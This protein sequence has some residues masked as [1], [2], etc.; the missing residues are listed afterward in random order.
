MHHVAYGLFNTQ[1]ISGTLR[2]TSGYQVDVRAVGGT[3]ID[4]KTTL[5]PGE[6]FNLSFMTPSEPGH[7]TVTLLINGRKAADW[8]I[9]TDAIYLDPVGS[10]IAPPKTYRWF[11][12][13]FN[14]IPDG[15]Y[16]RFTIPEGVT[17]MIDGADQSVDLDARDLSDARFAYEE[18]TNKTQLRIQLQPQLLAKELIFGESIAYVRY[19]PSEDATSDMLVIRP[20]TYV[21]PN[22]AKAVS[23]SSQ[24]STD[25]LWIQRQTVVHALDKRDSDAVNQQVPQIAAAEVE[26]VS[27]QKLDMLAPTAVRET[28]IDA[29]LSSL[30][31]VRSYPVQLED[32]SPTVDG[33]RLAFKDGDGQLMSHAVS[34]PVGARQAILVDEKPSEFDVHEPEFVVHD[35]HTT[36]TELEATSV[37][38]NVSDSEAPTAYHSDV[39]SL[40]SPMS[41]ALA[42]DAAQYKTVLVPPSIVSIQERPA[43]KDQ[44]SG[45]ATSYSAYGHDAAWDVA[46]SSEVFGRESK[47]IQFL[48]LSMYADVEI[49]GNFWDLTDQYRIDSFSD[50]YKVNVPNTI[51]SRNLP[52]EPAA[53]YSAPGLFAFDIDSNPYSVEST[54]SSYVTVPAH[55]KESISIFASQQAAMQVTARL[56]QWTRSAV[57]LQ[58]MFPAVAIQTAKLSSAMPTALVRLAVVYD[59]DALD[60][61]TV[62]DWLG[63]SEAPDAQA[64]DIH[65]SQDVALVEKATSYAYFIGVKDELN[66]GYFSTELA[67]L[68]NATDVWG[69]DPGMV[70]GV[71]QP[72][73][74]WTWAQA[75]PY[76]NLC[77]SEVKG[78]VSGG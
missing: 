18:A 14:A 57:Y 64:Q 23:V 75:V 5:E 1:Y 47:G 59:A 3:I 42:V 10:A 13:P 28:K 33:I 63:S 52:K 11:D 7:F 31:A 37:K 32:S 56:L 58:T 24:P 21:D 30:V 78:Y 16:F 34:Y 9:W 53:A 66:N 48:H 20:E 38:C 27:L 50:M 62:S 4:G 70:F 61:K 15:F 19:T 25:V 36:A 22:T 39:Q 51:K 74:L 44:S 35:Y 29:G 6:T 68:Q 26:F 8:H 71:K 72:S 12:I 55:S 69:M 73:G 67:A 65:V 2:N 45:S 46:V 76:T 40:T 60:A 43:S 54:T 49:L 77:G 17:A 41:I